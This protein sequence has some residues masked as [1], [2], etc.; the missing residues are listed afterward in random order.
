MNANEQTRLQR[1][2][3]L[4]SLGICDAL[5]DHQISIDEAE[6]LLFSPRSMRYCRNIGSLQDLIHLVDVGTELDPIQR[7]LPPMVFSKSLDE[8]RANARA[9]LSK[10]NSSDPQLE[11]WLLRLISEEGCDPDARADCSPEQPLSYGNSDDL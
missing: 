1:L 6:Q 3:A 11:P 7:L 9:V 2:L 8:I 4:L 10:T 5:A